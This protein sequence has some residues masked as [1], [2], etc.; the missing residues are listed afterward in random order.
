[1]LGDA[2]WGEARR[3]AHV[4]SVN[5]PTTDTKNSHKIQDPPSQEKMIT[6]PT[7]IWTWAV[8][9]ALIV[10]S[11]SFSW[12][13]SPE[14]NVRMSKSIQWFGGVSS[15]GNS[16]ARRKQ[17][18][19]LHGMNYFPDGDLI[20]NQTA[21]SRRK[22]LSLGGAALASSG[23]FTL[24]GPDGAIAA[25]K[26]EA[27]GMVDA[28]TVAGRLHSIPTFAIVDQKGVPYMVVG[29]DAKVTGY[30]FTT[31]DEA[32]RILKIARDSSEKS[33]REALAYLR[34]RRRQS[35]L[36]PLSAKEEEEEVGTNPWK[37]ARIS[38]VPLDF[39]ATL[40]IKSETNTGK[41]K[42]KAYFKVAPAEVC[43]LF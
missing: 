39:A 40:V 35:N 23:M 16:G 29:E 8:L 31:Y 37:N 21:T 10:P 18:W 26:S 6:L 1:M 25:E 33:V 7:C 2:G 3:T 17:I 13:S 11:S 28:S 32:S 9:A 43:Q 22:I 42:G 4:L 24:L 15:E 27:T 36:P 14:T 30:F 20:P 34:L 41:A 19:Q 12:A 5:H 38:S